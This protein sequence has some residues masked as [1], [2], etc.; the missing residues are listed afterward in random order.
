MTND[1]Q[2][3]ELIEQK[4]IASDVKSLLFKTSQP[5][6]FKAGQYM[7]IKT[8]SVSGYPAERDYSIA[9]TPDKKDIVEFGIQLLEDG[10]V[11]PE[12]FKLKIG[13][14]IQIKGPNGN[15]FIQNKSNKDPLILVAGGTGIIPFRSII[16]DVL[17]NSK[18]KIILFI[19]CKTEDKIAYKS[20]LLELKEK[21]KNFKIFITLTQ[22]K[23]SNLITESRRIDPQMVSKMFN[24][25]KNN[26]PSIFICG[27][28]TFVETANVSFIVNGFNPTNI[29]SER[30]G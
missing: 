15:F 12:L 29:R 26:N 27:P 7:S 14:K 20:E 13:N 8:T 21:H 6:D 28:S 17:K 18:Q 3:V 11:S 4:M 10:E 2:E 9:S 19:S 23:D 25:Y 5:I 22:Q 30:F 1:W 24:D 16:N